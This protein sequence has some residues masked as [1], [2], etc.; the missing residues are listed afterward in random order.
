MDQLE[1]FLYE[2]VGQLEII[3]IEQ[4]QGWLMLDPLQQLFEQLYDQLDTDQIATIDGVLAEIGLP[5]LPT[6]ASPGRT[7]SSN[8]DYVRQTG[9]S[10][11]AV[12]DIALHYESIS[13]ELDGGASIENAVKSATGTGHFAAEKPNNDGGIS[14]LFI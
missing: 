4:I 1:A 9:L 5:D 8:L 3:P 13:Q 11:Q 7:G 6:L 12:L 14:G 2:L 10:L